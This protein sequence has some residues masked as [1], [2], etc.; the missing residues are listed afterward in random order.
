MRSCSF[1]KCEE[2]RVLAVLFATLFL[3]A[4][5]VSAAHEAD[6]CDSLVK[7]LH[8]NYWVL[9]LFCEHT[10]LCLIED[11]VRRIRHRKLLSNPDDEYARYF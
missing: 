5:S 11:I 7:C 4:A 3:A 10:A 6:V 8:P 9:H 2:M 1:E